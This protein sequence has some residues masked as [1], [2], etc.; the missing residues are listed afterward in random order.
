MPQELNLEFPSEN[1]VI[2]HFNEQHSEPLNF[3]SPVTEEDQKD[4]RW[5][6][7]V[8]A[9]LYTT[10][11]DDKR[12]DKIAA[13]LPLLGES[14]LKS[15]FYND[16][17][18]QLFEQFHSQTNVGRLLT[19]SAS[20]PAILSLPWELLRFNDNYLFHDTPR[21]S[22]RR[23]LAN[24][25]EA[26]KP[27]A[28]KAKNRLHLLF[29]VSR[30]QGAGF[31]DPRTDPIA[32]LDALDQTGR[33]IEVEF[34]RPATLGNLRARLKDKTK[35][36]IDILHFDGHGAFDSQASMG[37]LLFTDQGSWTKHLVPATGLGL[38]LGSANIPLVIL[39]ACQSAAIGDSEEPMGTVAVQLTHAGVASVIAMTHSVHVNATRALFSAFYQH[40]TCGKGIGEALDNARS[41]LYQKPDR[42][43][44]Q[45]G[46]EHVTLKL[47][48]WFL[49]ALYQAGEDTPL[50][51]KP[52]EVEKQAEIHWGNLRTLQEAG[53]WGRTQ[54][55]W[56]IECA[57]VQDKTRR[58]TICGFGGQGKTYLAIETGQWLYR[59]GLFEK[60][61]FVD[62]AAF[63]GVDA[64][65]WAVSTLA[66]L[67]DK[68]LVDAQAATAALAQQATLLIL[69]NLEALSTESLNELLTVAKAW[70]EIGQCRVLMTT[71]TPDFHHP[72]YPIETQNKIH[73]S[74]PL[75]GLSNE[76]ALK[77]FERLMKLPPPPQVQPPK[78]DELLRLFQKVDFHPLS[79]GLLAS[80]L[81]EVTPD[82]LGERLEALLEETPDNRLLASLNL[83]LDR[84]DD[85]ARRLLP[86]LGVFQGGALEM[87]LLVITEMPLEKWGKLLFLLETTG[88]IQ[89]ETLPNINVPYLQFHPS[90]SALL[91]SD[92]KDLRHRHQRRYYELSHD[93]CVADNPNPLETRAIVKREF[94]NLLFAVKGALTE[95][96][97][98]AVEFVTYM[99]M[100]LYFFGL[101]DDLDQLNQQATK[102]AGKVG[103]Q[104]WY[105]S[106]HSVGQQLFYAG[107][108][109]EA[110]NIF[111]DILTGLG[112]IASYKH[113][114]TLGYLGR[115]FIQQG[116]AKQA[117][118]YYQQGLE[119]ALKLEQNKGVQRQTGLLYSDLGKL[120]TDMGRYKDA[121][122][123]YVQS[124]RIVQ[125]IGDSRGEVVIQ[126]GLGSLAIAQGKLAEAE[127]RYQ[128]ALAI[129]QRFHEPDSEAACWHQLGVVYE[130]TKQWE[131][132]E[133]AY[134][135]AANI[136]E[137]QGNLVGIAQTWYNLSLLMQK[138][139]KLADAE[140]W[141]RKAIKVD[142]QLNNPKD[143][144]INLSHLAELIQN[145]GNR[146]AEGQ[147]LAEK[148]LAIK[149]TLNPAMATI[150]T[151]YDILA[152][153]AEKQNDTAKASEYH[154][155]S[156]E[157]YQEFQ[158]ARYQ[159]QEYEWLIA[160]VLAA[161]DDAEARK[162]LKP[163]LEQMAKRADWKNIGAATQRILEGER[164]EMVLCEPLGWQ[165]AAIINAILRRLAGEV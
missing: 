154:R 21:I 89:V 24:R 106:K 55:L 19:I 139:G 113:C 38:I 34:L 148:A 13:R 146:L 87:M 109:S 14:L 26:K 35:P 71:R 132:A 141:C 157:A 8:Y 48:D 134:R 143:M 84:L 10:D 6:L 136:D 85:E 16:K 52:I 62:Y 15:V 145:Q 2:I 99:N 131:A 105:S 108:Y 126:V 25:D 93:L 54:E 164:D 18:T 1:Q 45:R 47:Y 100:F 32:V 76:D 119:I 137:R 94:P 104:N 46:Q 56:Q 53:F 149:K 9:Y 122:E 160:G 74:L 116:K 30:P 77:Y 79:I 92:N 111:T 124:L 81:K 78:R 142:K 36:P 58:F 123:A 22:I 90:L 5:Y 11:V 117:V 152:Q 50:L 31:I 138:R 95:E 28:I 118:T 60:V 125:E 112:T 39:S 110:G 150:W 12:A 68:S 42:I 158:G 133:H 17:A 97:D 129:F 101:Q 40:L 75:Q 165:D 73:Q 82:K 29:V 4:I 64:V 88:L 37:Y 23:R 72:D 140:A 7:E 83:S 57:F 3:Q 27:L 91:K 128:I 135:Q 151:T 65:G 115:C 163:V 80:R 147:Q 130:Q 161:V 120:L 61:C 44:L 153:I 86:S 107:D 63:Q 69:D 103:S 96:T 49:P 66:T 121:Q 144:A 162:K 20:H 155:Q 159:L 51:T 102:L 33:I 127:Q 98:Y 67:L 156:R 59:T 70:S 43:E 41:D 114:V